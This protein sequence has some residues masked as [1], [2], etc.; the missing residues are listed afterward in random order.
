MLPSLDSGYVCWG[1]SLGELNICVRAGGLGSSIY[2]LGLS[3]WGAPYA[4]CVWR[5][6]ELQMC[7]GAEGFESSICY[8]GA[9]GLGSSICL[10]GLEAWVVVLVAIVAQMQKSSTTVCRKVL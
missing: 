3:A 6:G 8:V 2:V 7:V 5:L 4:C 9:G 10:L 1:G